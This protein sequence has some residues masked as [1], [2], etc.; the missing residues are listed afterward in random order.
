MPINPF[1]EIPAAHHSCKGQGVVEFTRHLRRLWQR[2][3]LCYAQREEQREVLG[4]EQFW[5]C[6]PCHSPTPDGTMKTT[7]KACSTGWWHRVHRYVPF[8]QTKHP[9]LCLGIPALLCP[10][11]DCCRQQEIYASLPGKS[12]ATWMK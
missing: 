3:G 4:W 12:T 7:V 10:I 8:P 6:F 11:P 1:L 2:T 9:W 5:E